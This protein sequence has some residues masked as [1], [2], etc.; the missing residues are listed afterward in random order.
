MTWTV[1]ASSEQVSQL[2]EN[3][4]IDLIEFDSSVEPSGEEHIPA[5][6]TQILKDTAAIRQSEYQK[7][8]VFEYMVFVEDGQTKAETDEIEIFLQTLIG[9][10]NVKPPFIFKDK[11]RYWPCKSK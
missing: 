9:E 1:K 4:L 6:V 2:Q 3:P 10:R 11:L 8:G 5:A 7:A